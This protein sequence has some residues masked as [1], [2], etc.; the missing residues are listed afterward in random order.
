MQAVDGLIT[1]HIN[2]FNKLFNVSTCLELTARSKSFAG[3]FFM[4]ETCVVTLLV[5]NFRLTAESG[6]YL[7]APRSLSCDA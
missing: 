3:F 7:S 4:K 2:R 6:S 1:R 5:L